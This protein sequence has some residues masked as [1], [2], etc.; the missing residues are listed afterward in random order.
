MSGAR[1]SQQLMTYGGGGL[2]AVTGPLQTDDSTQGDTTY[3]FTVDIGAYSPTRRVFLCIHWSEGST[4]YILDAASCTIDGGAWDTG[5]VIQVGHS[6]G[7]T[8]FG[9]A[10]LSATPTGSGNVTVHLDFDG[11]GDA[12]SGVSIYPIVVYGLTQSN[13]DNEDTDE[14]VGTAFGLSDNVVVTGP[15][16]VVIAVYTGSTNTKNT[17]VS[18]VGLTEI[19]DTQGPIDP[20]DPSDPIRISAAM[21]INLDSDAS[22]TV[23][24]NITPIADS[25]NGFVIQSCH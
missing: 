16:A 11:S 22:L 7:S 8:G 3:Q 19:Y 25:G 24:A 12:V 10:L 5:D 20:D 13:V 1:F 17:A 23:Q 15:N 4:H 18:W 6:G 21:D 14:N 2:V 9:A